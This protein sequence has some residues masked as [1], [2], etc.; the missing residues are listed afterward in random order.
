MA[1]EPRRRSLCSFCLTLSEPSITIDLP[2]KAKPALYFLEFLAESL[3]E[4]LRNKKAPFAG[5]GQFPPAPPSGINAASATPP[6]ACASNLIPRNVPLNMQSTASE[7]M[8]ACFSSP[9]L[10]SSSSSSSSSPSSSPSSSRRDTETLHPSPGA[11]FDSPDF[12]FETREQQ[13]GS[14][15]NEGGGGDYTSRHVLRWPAHFTP[16]LTCSLESLRS[17]VLHIGLRRRRLSA[18]GSAQSNEK[19]L[20]AAATISLHEIMCGPPRLDFALK[21]RG[22]HKNG[23]KGELKRRRS[24]VIGVRTSGRGGGGGLGV[25][26]SAK[27]HSNSDSG[28]SFSRVSMYCAMEEVTTWSVEVSNGEFWWMNTK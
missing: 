8:M 21:G 10:S 13:L 26:K 3:D 28:V 27:K 24:Q 20:I 2:L 11:A 25:N 4:P 23:F 12:R 6:P 14:S 22:R 7:K 1:A 9:S 18:R 15:T 17:R 5:A 16:E 19:E